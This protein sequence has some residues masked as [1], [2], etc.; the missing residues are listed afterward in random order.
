[1]EDITA[2][3]VT[4]SF[5]KRNSTPVSNPLPDQQQSLSSAPQTISTRSTSE[6]LVRAAYGSNYDRL[7]EIEKKY[8]PRNVL[9]LNQNVKPA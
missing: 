5:P 6:E 8:D 3:P 4:P 7:V 1:M 9:W 2:S